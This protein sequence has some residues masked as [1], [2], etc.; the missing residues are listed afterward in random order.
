METKI[1]FELG[2]KKTLE[3]EGTRQRVRIEGGGVHRGVVVVDQRFEALARCGVPDPTVSSSS[4]R[5]TSEGA[6]TYM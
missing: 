2:V 3:L 1:N 6:G 4:A 5:G